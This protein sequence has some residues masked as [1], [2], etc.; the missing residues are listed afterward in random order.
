MDSNFILID[1]P[2]EWTSH[3]AV[4]KIRGIARKETGIKKIKVGHA[5]T[6]DPFATGLLII[7]IGRDATKR[8]DEFK[9]MR[10]TYVATLKLG[11]TSDTQDSD[12]VI[13]TQDSD[14]TKPDNKLVW[15]VLKSFTGKQ[16]QTPPM[17]SAKKVGGKKLYDLA[18]KGIE[19]ERQPSE[20]EIYNIKLL[21]Y[22][23]PDLKIEV[24]CSTGTYI[25]TLA[26][27]IGDKLDTGAYCDE[28]R[29]TRIGEYDVKNAVSPERFSTET[30]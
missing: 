18:R 5:G 4:A 11:A 13:T 24:D 16:L 15:D 6:L 30:P 17:Y 20:I 22:S 3:D 27:D 26:H 23:Y 1:K 14:S 8:L 28:L 21:D 10:K 19:I 29:R 2:K 9:A 12:G 7:G 25:R